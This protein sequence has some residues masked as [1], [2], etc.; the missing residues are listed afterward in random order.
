RTAWMRRGAAEAAQWSREYGVRVVTTPAA[1]MPLAW[2]VLR[3]SIVLPAD[4]AKWPEARLRSVLLHERMHLVRR[5]LLTHA[6]A[7]VACCL[8]WFHPLAWLALAKLRQER[9][10]AC[11]DAVLAAGVAAH[12]YAAHLMEVVRTMAGRRGTWADAP[13]MAESSNLE[14]RVRALLDRG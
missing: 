6:L 11:D 10:R 7:Q 2:G 1:P 12:D 13:A 9:E 5:D 3:P 4:A 8:Y 14:G